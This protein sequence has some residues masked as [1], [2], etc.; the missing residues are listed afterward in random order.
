MLRDLHYRD[1]G[2]GV[3]STHTSAGAFFA[4]FIVF[5]FIEALV[6]YPLVFGRLFLFRR[7]EGVINHF[8]DF[9][10]LLEL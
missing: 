2:T 6:I 4:A 7:S 10:A 9:T 1:H 8:A 5:R 3:A